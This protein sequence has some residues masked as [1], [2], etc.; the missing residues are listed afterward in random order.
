MIKLQ[1]VPVYSPN[2]KIVTAKTTFTTVMKC[3]SSKTKFKFDILN[4]KIIWLKWFESTLTLWLNIQHLCV[5]GLIY[6]QRLPLSLDTMR[7]P[8]CH[9]YFS[10]NNQW[11]TSIARPLGQ[12]MDVFREFEVWPKVYLRTL[13]CSVQFHVIL[14]RDI[15]R[16][17]NIIML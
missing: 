1:D 10:P 5:R 16:V 14:C 3:T 12:G 15:S 13:L 17:Y 8:I 4:Y 6:I 9:G 11:K 2:P 7:P